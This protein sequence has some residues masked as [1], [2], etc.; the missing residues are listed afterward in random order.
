LSFA[1]AGTQQNEMVLLSNPIINNQLK[2]KLSTAS[3]GNIHLLLTDMQGKKILSRQVN[4]SSGTTLLNI[5][6]P[7]NIAAGT[8]LLHVRGNGLNKVLKLMK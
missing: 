3:T 5:V 1:D 4:S 7:G 8:Y 6:L 2:I